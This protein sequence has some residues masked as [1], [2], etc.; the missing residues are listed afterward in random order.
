MPHEP[1]TI[2]AI[3]TPPGRGG[4]GIVR[5]SGPEA[6]EIA[7][8]LL[9]LQQPLQHAHARF[10]KVLDETSSTI[11]EAI[12]TA[13]L[14]P[15]SYT[16]EDLV[17]IAAHGSPVVLDYIVRRALSYGARLAEPGEFSRR[18]FLAGRLDL[19]QAEAI[20][21]LIAAQTLAQART[22]AQQLGGALSRRV[23]PIKQQ[24]VY[25][26][27]MLEAGMDFATGELD[28]VDTMPTARIAGSI[29]SIHAPLAA[30]AASFRFGSIQR[31]GV[32]LALVGRPNAGKS[33]LF[34]RLLDRD[35]AI[36]TATPGTTRDTIEET[37]SLEGIPIRLVDTAGLRSASPVEEA[38]ALGIARSREALADADLILLIR[39]A[40][41]LLSDEVVILSATKDT[42]LDTDLEPLLRDRPVI[43]I[44]NKV[45][46]LP[47]IEHAS[48]DIF[49]S[50]RTGQ[51]LETLRAAIVARL[52]AG[53]GAEEGALNNLRQHEAVSAALAA[54]TAAQ[55]ANR[56]RL[57][58]ELLLVDLHAALTAL[59]TLTG[60][61]TTDDILALIFSTFC[62]GK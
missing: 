22:A 44:R 51:G 46:L 54:L 2:V 29:Q 50:A 1:D 7:P 31:N 56:E 59:D 12:V 8:Q 5:L 28:D 9:A 48:D 25:L 30:L 52:R 53:A 14:T 42:S 20:H 6:L 26:I 15:H 3:S 55:A 23:A 16:G 17:E 36:V 41:E 37:F 4:I 45:D 58:H 18:A 21:D 62:I 11:D 40:T 19:T 47:H 10:T 43:R 38:E 35:R 49:T 61:T 24:L 27:A 60:T 34:N 13:F 57:P 39:D 32:R 33:S